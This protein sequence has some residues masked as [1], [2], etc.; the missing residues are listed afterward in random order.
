MAR[1][2]LTMLSAPYM[3]QLLS[4]QD[5]G[6]E[7]WRLLSLIGR[8]NYAYKDKYLLSASIRRDGSS[9]FAPGYNWGTFPSVS[10]GWRIS[11]ESFFPKLSFLDQVKFTGSFGLAGNNNLGNYEYIPGVDPYN[12]PFG[13]VLSPGAAISF[14]RQ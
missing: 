2:S 7:E 14:T 11:D 1:V 10:G 4:P 13:G 3:R 12:Y 8:V 5:A 6:D 9:R